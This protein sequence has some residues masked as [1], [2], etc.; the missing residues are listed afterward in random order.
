MRGSE[1]EWS[2]I[3]RV[4]LLCGALAACDH[5]V[6][7]GETSTGA[8]AGDASSG[9]AA[10]ATGSGGAG[11]ATTGSGGTT[12][13]GGGTTTAGGAAGSSGLGGSGGT[14]GG[15]GGA[16]PD[17]GPARPL[18]C[19]GPGGTPVP[20]D[21]SDGGEFGQNFIGKWLLCTPEGWLGTS[22]EAGFE[23]APDGHWYQLYT[24]PSGALERGSGPEK[25]GT[26]TYE[27]WS[28][29]IGIKGGGPSPYVRAFL[30]KEPR[31]M[32]IIDEGIRSAD[33]VDATLGDAGTGPVLYP[34]DGGPVP[35]GCGMAGIPVS[36]DS[37]AALSGELVGSWIACE[38]PSIFGTND[39]LGI[40]FLADGTW[41]KLYASDSGATL[42]G[43]G[44]G[45]QGWWSPDMQA[46]GGIMAFR[47]ETWAG[48]GGAIRVEPAFFSSPRKLRLGYRWSY[49]NVNP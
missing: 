36:I 34:H 40:E 23:F 35:A 25:E 31:R 48:W 10:G 11:G 46:D 30:S 19:M 47:I 14:T 37:A 29:S 15:S 43:S 16:I 41:Y 7:I 20:W 27:G 44:F 3:G 22:N 38:R 6:V 32:R 9:S 4:S 49:I 45:S 8:D 2:E 12:S 39:E 42:R 33:Y 24:T 5:R 28:Y 1:I 26:W 18:A 17:A 21:G 13:G